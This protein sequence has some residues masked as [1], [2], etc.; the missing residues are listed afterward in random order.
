MNAIELLK[1][2]PVLLVYVIPG[3]VSVSVIAYM[4]PSRQKNN[5]LLFLESI[6]LSYLLLAIVDGAR[7]LPYKFFNLHGSYSR[8]DPSSPS[9]AILLITCAI[10]LGYLIGCLLGT[11]WVKTLASKLGL[12]VN[13]H[14]STW[15]AV[16]CRRDKTPY[17]RAYLLNDGVIYEG[18]LSDYSCDPNEENREIYLIGYICYSYASNE[19]AN[20]YGDW[21]AGVLLKQSD[22][23]RLE[24]LSV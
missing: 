11:R 13:P 12:E 24:I 6:L 1:C 10:A 23:S 8:L 22:I 18:F 5:F 4:W 15:N 7:F 14:A 21:N 17:I 16:L 3:Y 2:L 20:N 19:L 9:T